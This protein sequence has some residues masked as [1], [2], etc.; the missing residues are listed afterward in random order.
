MKFL[1]GGVPTQIYNLDPRQLI[2][3][4]DIHSQHSC[5]SSHWNYPSVANAT[6]LS[7]KYSFLRLDTENEKIDIS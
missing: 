4:L 1:W 2:S 6:R 3:R 7:Q 5:K